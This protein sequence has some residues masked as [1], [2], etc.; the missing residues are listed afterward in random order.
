MISKA[1]KVGVGVSKEYSKNVVVEYPNLIPQ[2]LVIR[3]IHVL[4]PLT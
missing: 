4:A 1:T 2:G 3:K